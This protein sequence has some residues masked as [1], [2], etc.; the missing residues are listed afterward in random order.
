LVIFRSN[1]IQQLY[2]T[3]T[4]TFQAF[5]AYNKRQQYD[6]TKEHLSLEYERRRIA[7]KDLCGAAA[8]LA[9]SASAQCLD[10]VGNFYC[11]LVSAITYT[12]VGGQGSYNKITNMD[13][14]SGTCSSSPFGYSGSLSPFNEPVSIDQ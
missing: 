14:T 5:L 12:G 1:S 9:V 10:D 6:H 13:S 2:N 11:D 7:M 4:T 3:L 8:L